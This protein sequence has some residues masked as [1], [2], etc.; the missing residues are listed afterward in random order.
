MM[1]RDPVRADE[2]LAQISGAGAQTVS[3]LRRM[4]GGLGAGDPTG[5]DGLDD[6]L[7]SVRRTGVRVSLSRPGTPGRLAP[8]VDLVAYRVVQEAL[9]NVLRHSGPGA[10]ATVILGWAPGALTIEVSDDGRG[11]PRVDAAGLSTGHGLAGLMARVSALGGRFEA[12]PGSGGGFRV[13][14]T[15]PA[16]PSGRSEPS[17]S[18]TAPEPSEHAAARPTG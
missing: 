3:E 4:L 7:H 14:A 15:L 11:Q 16:E 18:T 1:L 13:C 9:T 5:L 10:H 12:R 2:A 6:L 17:G 8:A